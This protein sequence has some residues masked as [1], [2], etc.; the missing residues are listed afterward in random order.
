MKAVS[1]T[2]T[3]IPQRSG[4][5]CVLAAIAMAAGCVSWGEMWS[6]ADLQ[7]VVDSKGV[8]DL[9]PWLKRAGFERRV[10]YR[11]VYVHED[12]QE[13]VRAL[14][15]K[16]RALISCRSL[17]N[18]DGYHMVFW[19]GQRV[20]DPH[21]GHWHLGW[22]FFKHLTSMCIRTL[23]IFD[24]SVPRQVPIVEVPAPTAEPAAAT[25]SG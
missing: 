14:L 25:T 20:W 3:L 16:R 15:W 19:D 24:D 5:D 7:A 4:S 1:S 11:T 17:N 6:D 8:G 21:E 13:P 23:I 18:E 22:Q 12:A 9:D 2:T 10:H